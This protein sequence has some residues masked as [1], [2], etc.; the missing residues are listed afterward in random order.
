MRA[1]P[2]IVG[3][4]LLCAA[5]LAGIA[6]P[7]AANAYPQF[8][9]SG[10]TAR[11][12]MCHYAPAGG[13]LINGWGRDEAGETVSRGGNGAL[14][15]GLWDGPRWLALGGNL[16]LAGGVERTAG[17]A[18]SDAFAFPMQ[19]ELHARIAAG[20]FS[21]AV[22]L[23][24]RSSGRD[25]DDDPPT[26]NDP[27][28][29]EHY[30]MWR[31]ATTGPYVRAGRFYAPLGLRTADH[32]AYIRRALGFD[33]W[34]E[35]YGIGAGWIAGDTWEAHVTGYTRDPLTELG[36]PGQGFAALFEQR[37]LDSS[38]AWGAHTKLHFDDGNTRSIVGATGKLYLEGPGLLLLAEL[39]GVIETFDDPAADSRGQ[40][41]GHLNATL[42]ATRGLMLGATLEHLDTDITARG[43]HRS[44]AS[45]TIQY[46][47]YA[48]WE[49]MLRAG[50][51]RMAGGDTDALALA[52][53]HY[54][55]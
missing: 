51:E 55:L 12:T 10:G 39:D 41:V 18:G 50:L 47:P 21:L 14:L 30:A 15:H 36:P 45:V 38:A 3:M 8:Q 53:L 34:Q 1:A 6:L 52:L 26:D 23:G 43:R 16:R 32:T 22:T 19:A 29:R 5:V 25:S 7:R 40:L 11:C 2:H 17:A 35:S 27:I 48:H 54:Y 24:P 31:E 37:L 13:G 28:S 20:D 4:S 42:F 46:F 44:S 33:A 49:W 9:L